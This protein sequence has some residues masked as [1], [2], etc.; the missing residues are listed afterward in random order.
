MSVIT[1]IAPEKRTITNFLTN[2]KKNLSF[3][4]IGAFRSK[5]SRAKPPKFEWKHFSREQRWTKPVEAQKK[6]CD[7]RKED[8]EEKMKRK[9]KTLFAGSAF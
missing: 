4:A 1:R 3:S 7:Q 2:E 8:S 6:V 5:F 9:K